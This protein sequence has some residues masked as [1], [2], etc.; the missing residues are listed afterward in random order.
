MTDQSNDIKSQP[1]TFTGNFKSYLKLW[2][3][4]SLLLLI[5]FGLLL[6]W[7][8]LRKKRYFYQ[9]TQLADTSFSF[10][11]KPK[12]MFIGVWAALIIWFV[13][14]AG[15]EL[16]PQDKGWQEI[17]MPFVFFNIIMVPILAFFVNQALKFRRFYSTF[18]GINFAF[19][20]DY[21]EAFICVA[22]IFIFSPLTLFLAYPYFKWRFFSFIYNRTSFGGIRCKF[23]GK[24]RDLYTI[25]MRNFMI[26]IFP[27]IIAFT[28]PLLAL[29]EIE[30]ELIKTENLFALIKYY[31]VLV[32][33]CTLLGFLAL[34]FITLPYLKVQVTNWTW[35][36]LSIGSIKMHSNAAPWRLIR[37][38]IGNFFMII[39]SLGLLSPLAKI[40]TQQF[41]TE[42]KSFSGD[43]ESL[44]IKAQN[45]QDTHALGDN[46][47][48]FSGIDLGL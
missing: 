46:M 12:S 4:N 10:T 30:Y 48:D 25:Y 38:S 39:F 33:S 41:W 28:L 14:Q 23:S 1:I 32:I 11:A 2:G 43:L 37:L 36:S 22:G 7:T 42:T 31:G 8:M 34:F 35:N 18:R 26:L 40:R 17:V 44:L 21:V 3:E 15:F 6:P 16:I 5:S 13:L 19:K 24:L 20:K 29:L 27:I 47:A 45:F 9:H